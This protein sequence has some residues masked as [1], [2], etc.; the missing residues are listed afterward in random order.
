MI[1]LAVVSS[2]C[3][4]YVPLTSQVP[5]LGS[6]VRIEL[7]DRGVVNVEPALGHGVTTVEGTVRAAVA[8][9][10]TISLASVQRRQ[11]GIQTWA[12]ETLVLKP[13]DIRAVSERRLSHTRT[14]VAATSAI[15]LAAAGIIAI[16][17]A[18]GDASGES[19]T[20]PPPVTPSV[21]S[22]P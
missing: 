14:T 9:S 4:Q 12:G 16:A 8:D 7:S 11:S 6:Q 20:K 10:V 13:G 19:G 3:Y 1:A 18:G 5:P 2:G 17:K 15:T 21:R 22:W